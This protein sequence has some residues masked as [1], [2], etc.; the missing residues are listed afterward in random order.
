MR[1]GQL[2]LSFFFYVS[3]V[4]SQRL[5]VL[6]LYKSFPVYKKKDCIEISLYYWISIML[7]AG[8]NR[9]LARPQ[10]TFCFKS[11]DKLHFRHINNS[12]M[13]ISITASI[14]VFYR[15]RDHMQQD[16]Q[17]H[18][19]RS[20]RALDYGPRGTGLESCKRTIICVFS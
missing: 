15:D 5:L 7:Y 2:F 20:R 13:K 17:R 8:F 4:P 3:K 18:D 6:D 1:Y 14:Q 11:V 19:S 12:I 9:C 10:L 16:Q